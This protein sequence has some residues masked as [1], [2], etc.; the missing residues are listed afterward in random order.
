[1]HKMMDKKKLHKVRYE[2]FFN[3]LSK[4]QN[5]TK[6]ISKN[7]SQ[8]KQGKRENDHYVVLAFTHILMKN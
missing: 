1:M 3:L 8:I 2:R 6:E 5:C 4:Q 7:D